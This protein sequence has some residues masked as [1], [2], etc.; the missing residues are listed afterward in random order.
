MDIDN[1][2]EEDLMDALNDIS[3]EDSSSDEKVEPIETI[4][5]VETKNDVQEEKIESVKESTLCIDGS[6]LDT[7]VPLLKELLQHKTIEISIKIK[8]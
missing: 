5:P 7:L 1:I 8:D 2:S 3:I 4:A 6:S